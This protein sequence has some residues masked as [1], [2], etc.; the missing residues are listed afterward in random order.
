MLLVDWIMHAN[1]E[2][3]AVE[4]IV[5]VDHNVKIVMYAIVAATNDK[6]LV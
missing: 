6:M 2:T 3:V 1:V 4:K 5:A